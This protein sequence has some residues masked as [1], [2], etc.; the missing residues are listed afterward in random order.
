MST[1]R[2]NIKNL[3]A[4]DSFLY[5]GNLYIIFSNGRI[6]YISFDYLI[7]KLREAYPVYDNLLQLAFLHND[8]V[9]TNAGRLLLGIDGVKSSV[10]RQWETAI[11][12]I[13][14][15]IDF[16]DIDNSFQTIGEWTSM[17]LD[18][19]IYAM[20]L[21]LGCKDG[22]YESILLP[23]IQTKVNATPME[24]TL[25]TKVVSINTKFG[26]VAISADKEGLFSAE[27]ADDPIVKTKVSEHAI[28]DR[29]SLRSEWMDIDLLSYDSDYSF[30][31]VRNESERLSKAAPNFNS[32]WRSGE[33]KRISQLGVEVN[34]MS[35]FLQELGIELDNID[36][37]FNSNSSTF[38]RLRN[39]EIRRADIKH[40]KGGS[41]LGK[42]IPFRKGKDRSKKIL[43]TTVVPN[44]CVL[45]FYDRVEM[46]REGASFIL[47]DAPAYSVRSYPQSTRYRS[48]VTI[49]T[50]DELILHS[51]ETFSPI[52]FREEVVEQGKVL[53][54]NVFKM[55]KLRPA[56]IFQN[57]HIPKVDVEIPY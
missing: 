19:R 32:V 26:A 24:K 4:I 46:S 16:H 1:L 6:A 8:Y 25:D 44:G 31:Y 40:R 51:T 55:R 5:A 20:R 56:D 33:R 45:N 50:E 9:N 3:Q 52:A 23:D 30:C 14:F 35:V 36:Y 34:D 15:D 38:I 11:H 2:F 43:S 17:P 28:V 57:L 37:C 42:V 18:L 21:F 54:N 47:S 48:L 27:I 12:E 39:G 13:K 29:R 49:N 22:L 53:N 10:R 7:H 41:E